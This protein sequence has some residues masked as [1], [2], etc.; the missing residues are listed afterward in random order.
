MLGEGE[1]TGVE[2]DQADAA[3]AGECQQMGVGHLAITDDQRNIVIDERYVVS[4]E[5]VAS[6][7]A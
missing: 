3:P 4:Q 6:H 5:A 2:G 1:D 7:G